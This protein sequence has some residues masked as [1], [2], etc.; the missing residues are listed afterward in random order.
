MIWLIG[1]RGML[2]TELSEAL[3]HAGLPFLGTDR[4]VSI[5]DEKALV[6]FAEGKAITWIINCA[7]Y[8]AVDKAEDEGELCR[9]L[10]ALGPANI[11]RTAQ[12]IGAS[13][14]HISTDY[15]FSGDASRPYTE[16]DPVS[17]SGVYGKTKADG[18]SA[19]LAACQ[20]TVIVRTAWLYGRHGPNFVYT[21]LRLMKEKEIIGVVADQRGSPTWAR[22]LSNAILA[23]VKSGS[24]QYGVFHFTNLGEITW[25][26]FAVEIK[27]LGRSLSLLEKDCQIKA[28][29]TA[30]YPT[31][32][33]RPAYSV[34]S[35]DKIQAAY[36]IK[37]PLWKES[38]EMFLK[39][40]KAS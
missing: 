19:A 28:L 27:W 25:H 35:K 9:A 8:T 4:E 31:K 40:E 34:L 37:I 10:N 6:D 23:I 39:E 13:L 3:E 5:L 30:E 2:G 15:V 36:G 16:D 7:A 22:D 18:E 11:A 26:D 24:P 29:S 33:R 21:M 38:L 17:P 32:A 20:R 1:N 14:L 12:K